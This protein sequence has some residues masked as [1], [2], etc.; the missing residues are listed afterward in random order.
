MQQQV[1]GPE[2]VLFLTLL[3][4]G[5][6]KSP[7]CPHV[8]V[9]QAVTPSALCICHKCM[10]STCLPAGKNIHVFLTYSPTYPSL[11]QSHSENPAP[12]CPGTLS[13]H[14]APNP[15]STGILSTNSKRKGLLFSFLHPRPRRETVC[16][17]VLGLD[18]LTY[19]GD[20]CALSE[21]EFLRWQHAHTEI[22]VV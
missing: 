2:P 8:A 5:R 22:I 15:C 20:M 19:S 4:Q 9:K 3:T 10:L 11:S 1:I 16:K 12:F 21:V 18:P 6:L 14:S 7:N 17:P 13:F